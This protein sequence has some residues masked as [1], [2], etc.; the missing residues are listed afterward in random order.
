MRTVTV[1]INYANLKNEIESNYFYYLDLFYKTFIVSMCIFDKNVKPILF[2]TVI[3]NSQYNY[4]LHEV[5]D[6]QNRGED[7]IE[8]ID[9][10]NNIH[11]FTDMNVY[12]MEFFEIKHNEKK[13]NIYNLTIDDN[14]NVCIT[15]KQVGKNVY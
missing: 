8:L 10:K 15:N 5:R 14:Y 1:K 2:S 4:F 3:E 12:T 6:A 9:P 13:P 11:T 7:I